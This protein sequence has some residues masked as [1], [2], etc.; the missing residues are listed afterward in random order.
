MHEPWSTTTKRIVVIGSVILVFLLLDRIGDLWRPITLSLILA[1][2]INP[3]ADM[4]TRRLRLPRTLAVALIYLGVIALI[5]IIPALL[6]PPLITQIEGLVDSIP[7]LID[8]LGAIIDE[9]L[10]I[11]RFRLDLEDVYAQ[12]SGAIEGVISSAAT[13]TINILSGVAETVVLTVFVLVSSF[14]LVKDSALIIQWLEE[15]TPPGFRH[16]ARRLRQQIATSW[17]AFLRGQLILCIVMGIIVGVTMAIVGLPNALII[18]LL[19]GVLE[20]IPNLGPTIASVPTLIIAFFQGS[21]VLDISNA[22]F[23]VLILIINIAL[24]QLENSFLVPRIMG[25]SLNLHPLVV[26]V[27]AITGARLGGVL[28][29]LLAAPTV[30]TLRVLVEYIYRR[31]LDLPPF[32]IDDILPVD[33]DIR[34]AQSQDKPAVEA[35]CAKIWDGEDYVPDVWEDWVQD[36]QGQFSLILFGDKPVG[37]SKLTQLAPGEW[38]LE[39]LRVD[40]AYQNRGIARHLHQHNLDLVERLDGDR[41]RLG[42]S[43]KN[44]AV[45]TLVYQSG[46][47]LIGRYA[48]YKA[49][50]DPNTPNQL[51]PLEPEH[52]AQVWD[53]LNGSS[54]FRF[55]SLYEERWVWPNLTEARLAKLLAAGRVWGVDGLASIALTS[56][57]TPKQDWL[58]VGLLDGQDGTLV[59]AAQSLRRL[60]FDQ[61]YTE[62]VAIKPIIEPNL[63]NA[64]NQ[65]GYEASWDKQLWIFE[66]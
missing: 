6:V 34:P 59:S 51:R 3:L 36:P 48:L 35:L 60:A 53:L 46:F 38:W 24:Q 27:A 57:P 63:L 64:L 21:T 44:E 39:G 40:P 18:G 13:R 5:I 30:A 1:Y 11:G 37:L 32:P 61:G 66:K 15:V 43:S 47:R 45:H 55:V 7:D 4:M 8:E 17:N 22:W 23:T 9:P 26:L 65:A 54:R 10:I 29:I 62:G 14:Y 56:E 12:A 20:F 33:L 41:V 19:F 2:I 28:G 31:L 25:H 42:T 50:L 49:S 16:D 52:L 58:R